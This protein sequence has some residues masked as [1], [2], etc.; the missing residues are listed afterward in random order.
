MKPHQAT[1]TCFWNLLEGGN[2]SRLHFCL[3]SPRNTAA[4]PPKTGLSDNLRVRLWSKQT[5]PKWTKKSE[6]ATRPHPDLVRFCLFLWGQNK[7]KW[8]SWFI[9]LWPGWVGGGPSKRSRSGPKVQICHTTSPRSRSGLFVFTSR[10]GPKV[11]ICHP[12]S[13]RPR[14]VW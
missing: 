7:Q 8:C 3:F 12:P 14:S 9:M 4:L 6:I 1:S 11:Q 13:P 10:S 2:E 5:E